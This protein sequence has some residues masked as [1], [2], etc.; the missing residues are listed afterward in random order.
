MTEYFSFDI[1]P[2][3]WLL[4][5]G[6]SVAVIVTLLYGFKAYRKA[7]RFDNPPVSADLSDCPKAS[8]IVYA[9]GGSEDVIMRA[10]EGIMR[11]DYPDYEVV[12]VCDGSM[13][14]ANYLSEAIATIYPDVY[15]T[16]MQPGSHNLSRRKL[17]T[18]IGVKAAKG[19]VV[20]TT[21]ANIEIPSERWLSTLMSPFCGEGGQH[22]D[23]V[24]GVSRMDFNEL[25]GAGRWYRQF[26]S[27]I[28]DA[29]WIGYAA[30]GR[31]YRGDG[32]N[33]AFRRSVFFE[34]KGYARTINLHYGDDDLFI[35]EIADGANTRVVVDDE[36]IL[37]TKWEEAANRV[38][39]MRKA[40][41]NFTSRWLVRAPFVRAMTAKLMQWI[42]PGL[43]TAALLTGLPN[44]LPAAVAVCLL[45]TFWGLEIAGY[46]RLAPRLKAI[47]LWWA[48]V[49]FWL[50]KSPADLVFRYR[51][52]SSRKK[53]FTYQRDYGKK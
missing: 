11:Q 40:R 47:R 38:W 3:A 53:N 43:A 12:V 18:T 30:A 13:A 21:V 50:W 45:L 31:P 51:H 7:W 2:L 32:Y 16:F 15:V 49:P 34:H 37:V 1:S 35:S 52:Y 46:R 39:A 41:Y 10:I 24:L 6:M 19:D 27:V 26:D 9:L 4:L 29:L 33:L 44:L 36:S 8:V 20:I 42:V 14:Q 48:V 25:T 17:A 5:S 22:I 23:V 28:S